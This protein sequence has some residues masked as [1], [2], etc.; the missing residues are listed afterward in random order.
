MALTRITIEVQN[1]DEL[2]E[3]YEQIQIFRAETKY[4]TYAEITTLAT[5]IEIVSGQEFYDY[6]DN[7]GSDFYWY[8]WRFW[9]D[10]GAYSKYMG[11][12]QGYTPNATYCTFDDVKRLLRSKDEQGRIRFS[13]Y[14]QNL[15]KGDSAQSV[16]LRALSVSPEYAGFQKYTI[17]F[18]SATEFNVTIG[19]MSSI[20]QTYVGSGN[21]GTDFESTENSVRINSS[22]W[23]GTPVADDIVTFETFSHMSTSD[24][25][26]FIQDAEVLVDVIIEE[27]V[28][29]L[30]SK[31]QTLRFDRDTVPKAV[32]AACSRFAAFF[33]YSTIYNE[34]T[35]SGL[36]DNLNDISAIANRRIEDLST[37]PRQAIRYLEGWI[38]KYT[39]FFNPD[40]DA[41]V[42]SAPRWRSMGAFF[43]AGG[44]AYVGEGLKLPEFDVFQ[45]NVQMNYKGLLDWD[46]L[47]PGVAGAFD[48]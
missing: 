17:T 48:V 4:G 36:P 11:P 24:A 30:E 10:I 38:K 18:T 31:D 3:D 43:D 5:R 6:D 8:K 40:T 22:D 13:D 9:N 29:Y 32:R 7:D 21:I 2:M 39:E 15:D 25:I 47:T 44:V 16:S 19:E 1:P 45:E 26:K 37:L 27:N 46:L 35:I 23:S 33:I 41:T 42:T 28:R 14:Y 34:Q 20:A 12:M